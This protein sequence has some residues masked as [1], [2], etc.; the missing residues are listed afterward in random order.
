MRVQCEPLRVH[1]TRK[2]V[3]LVKV[4]TIVQRFS[5]EHD[6]AATEP[7]NAA[8]ISGSKQAFQ[9][10]VPKEELLKFEDVSITRLNLAGPMCADLT[11]QALR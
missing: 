11:T 1:F 7:S 9:S 10:S 8:V 5:R 3:W 6:H 4:H 2:R